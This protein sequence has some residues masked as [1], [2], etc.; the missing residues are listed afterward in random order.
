MADALFVTIGVLT[1]AAMRSSDNND[2]LSKT[3]RESGLLG[4][5]IQTYVVHYLP[6]TVVASVAPLPKKQDLEEVIGSLLCAIT[7][8]SGYL[9]FNNPVQVYGVE[10]TPL[11]SFSMAALFSAVVIAGLWLA[12]FR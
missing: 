6:T 11:M 12:G 7:F 10:M 1:M 5:G 9:S 8:F 4:Y 2:L 3:A